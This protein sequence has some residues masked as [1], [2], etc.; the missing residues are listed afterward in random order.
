MKSALALVIVL[1]ACLAPSACANQGEGSLPAFGAALDGMPLTRTRL[2]GVQAETGLFPAMA[3]FFVQWP[4]DPSKTWFYPAETLEAVREFGAAPCLTWEP[5]F[6]DA[7][8]EEGVIPAGRILSG[9][10]DGYIQGFARRLREHG[11]PVVVR[12]AHEPNIPRY[13]WGDPDGLGP[14]SPATYR[15]LF[16]YIVNRFRQ[17]D[18]PNVRFAFCP[19][20]ESHPFEDWNRVE[21][22]Y[23]GSDVVDLVGMDGYNWGDTRTL[24]EHGWQS[25]FRSFKEIFKDMRARLLDLAPGK[26]LVVFETACAPTGGDKAAW[27]REMGE[28]AREWGLAALCWFQADKETDWR[29]G[30]GVEPGA[31][32]GLGTFFA[33]DDTGLRRVLEKTAAEGRSP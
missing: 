27:I 23:P 28:T 25:S 6:I 13:H 17:E 1:S 9:E 15:K 24:E 2:D 7:G 32:K 18:A 10:Y 8:G 20:A 16:R 12:L 26:P 4:E 5:M 19:N 31:L 30:A 21:N 33:L 11:G 22:Y 29:L 3:V 14:A